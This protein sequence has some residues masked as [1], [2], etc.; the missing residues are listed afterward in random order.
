MN[1]CCQ[2]RK[3]E[4]KMKTWQKQQKE[5]GYLTWKEYLEAVEEDKNDS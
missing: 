1:F 2:I 3:E 4:I 5:K